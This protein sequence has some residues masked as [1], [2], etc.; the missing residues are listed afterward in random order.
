[1]IS[2]DWSNL[3]KAV[4]TTIVARIESMLK[5]GIQ[6]TPEGKKLAVELYDYGRTFI[7]AELFP[8]NMGKTFAEYALR[9]KEK[10][11]KAKSGILRNLLP[12]HF[13]RR[14]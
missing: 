2:G 10:E 5:N 8:K 12:F 9:R 4:V 7:E 13:G 1:M 11:E 14:K 3:K 6:L